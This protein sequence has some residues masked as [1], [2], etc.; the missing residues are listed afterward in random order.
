MNIK[1]LLP[2]CILIALGF[3][4]QNHEK[5]MPAP[6]EGET[7]ES[8]H[9]NER[10][11][12]LNLQ[13]RGAPG[14]DWRAANDQIMVDNY[15]SGMNAQRSSLPAGV[16][17]GGKI[18]ASWFERGSNNQ[19]GS[20]IGIDYDPVSNNIYSISAGGTLWRRS[21]DVN[22]WTELNRKLRF[23]GPH[24]KVVPLANGGRRLL[25]V[26]NT[27]IWYSDD[28]G[29]TFAQSPGIIVN[30]NNVSAVDEIVV[31]NTGTTVEVYCT[32]VVY[33]GITPNARVYYSADRG[34]TFS[35]I[36]TFPN[37][38][39]EQVSMWHPY[40][41]GDC[42]L[43]IQSSKLYKLEGANINLLS[44]NNIIPTDVSSMLR[45][46]RAPNGAITFYVMSNNDFL[47]R[48]T[49][50]GNTWEARGPLANTAWNAGLEVSISDPNKLFFGEVIAYK[51]YN[52][53]TSWEILNS[54]LDYYGNIANKLHADIMSIKFFRRSN[55]QEFALISNHGGMSVSYDFLQ[56]VQN[57][58]M[59]GLNVSQYYDIHTDPT[60]PNYIYAGSQDQGYQ[61]ATNAAAG[62]SLLDFTQIASGDFGHMV[63]SGNGK[64]FWKQYVYGAF[65]YHHD[66][67]S[68]DGGSNSGWSLSGANK[69]NWLVPTAENAFNPSANKI[70]VGG[71]NISG[72]P[73]S[74]LVELTAQETPPYTITATQDTFNFFTHS[75]ITGNWISAIAV[76]PL[77]GRYY[78]STSDGTFFHREPNGIWQKTPGF[79]G[80]DGNT[81]YGAYILPSKLDPNV[82]WFCGS[83]YNNPPVWKSTDG[84]Q[85]FTAISNGLPSTLVQYLATSP[86]EKFIYAATDVGP[87]VY[88]VAENIWYSLLDENVPLQTCYTVEYLAAQNIV[89][90]G[91]YGRGIWDFALDNMEVDGI[92]YNANCGPGSGEIQ[93]ST[94]GGRAP[95]SYVWS[96]GLTGANLTGLTTGTYTV[97]VSDGYGFTRTQA[98]NVQIGGKPV[99][100]HDLSLSDVSCG[101]VSLKWQGPD[102]GSYQIRY[103]QG[104]D[105]LWTVLGNVGNVKNYTLHLDPENGLN[106]SIAVR[107]VCPGNQQ[108]AWVQ[109]DG[110]LQNCNFQSNT[111]AAERNSSTTV[112]SSGEWKLYP[113]PANDWVNLT[114]DKTIQEIGSLR[115]YD[116]G[117]TLVKYKKNL[118]LDG[119]SN[120]KLSLEGL[121]PGVYFISTDQNKA[122]K[123]MIGL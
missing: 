37:I 95:F 68:V 120:Y 13:H 29:A 43:M 53:G 61:R 101:L 12:F 8:G 39:H 112:L 84:G 118:A 123:L 40:N 1:V 56:T 70:L 116:A 9:L 117:G 76:N 6:T 47:Y 31:T 110:L 51:S 3:W 89:R 83:G 78:V 15:L 52:G 42:Y 71:G 88:D 27:N 48:S 28:E 26:I 122:Q 121:T 55:N 91:T 74:Y 11:R 65:T 67:K 18:K 119:N 87:Y 63:F 107:Y 81:M 23:S 25:T 98:F 36:S 59:S 10:E 73:G 77:N 49:D 92:S 115:V 82:V 99:K 57:I 62:P 97:T 54:Y 104:D 19:A 60:D 72:G 20:M 96:N 22:N 90:F 93:A 58:G 16:F 5:P 14:N 4:A 103:I 102:G 41:T 108:S 45:G 64:H 7:D 32:I 24:I 86:D 17:A 21:L 50:N 80:P 38:N 66:P 100:P 2:I 114:F 106:Y 109:A 113:N 30:A 35:L 46:Y 111:V 44:T 33:S 34:Q 69:P 75:N 79:N 85:T 94:S 105:A